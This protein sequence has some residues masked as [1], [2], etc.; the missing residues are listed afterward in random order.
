MTEVGTE[1]MV[2][3]VVAHARDVLDKP[4]G[5]ETLGDLVDLLRPRRGGP[6]PRD[7][8]RALTDALAADNA[9]RARLV[10]AVGAGLR[11][12][13]VVP[14]LVESGVLDDEGVLA[15]LRAALGEW[16]LPP[17]FP[18]DDA[19]AVIPR[20]FRRGADFHWVREMPAAEW[21]RF[22]ELILPDGDRDRDGNGVGLDHE[23]VRL[24]LRRLAQRI[25]G[26]GTDAE[27]EAGRSLSDHEGGPFLELPIAT[28]D[29]LGALDGGGELASARKRLL[30]QT[31]AARKVVHRLRDEKSLYGT[32][33]R[34]TRLTRRLI[35]QL[36]RFELLC[37]LLS[38]TDRG[39]R[40][41]AL[42]VLLKDLVV[43]EQSD[44]RLR[45]RIGQGVDLLAFEITEH[46]AAK[47]EKYI[48]G[49]RATYLKVLRAA[50]LGGAWV[51]VFAIFKLLA[52]KLSLPLAAEAFVYGLNYA[53]C[54]VLIYA[55]G[56]T[57]A[58]KQPAITASA[59]A[60]QLDA[61]GWRQ[62]G[63]EGVARS[64]ERVWRTQFVSF[65]GNLLF[66]FPF[67]ALVGWSIEESAGIEVVT[68]DKARALLEANHAFEGPTLGFAAIAGVLLFVAGLFQGAVDNR[69]VY[70][71]LEAR[72]AEHPRLRLLGAKRA[73]LARL[74]C[75]HAGGIAS[76][77]LLGFLLGSAG[78]VGRIFGLPIDI[79]HI[80][81]SSAHVGVA[82]LDAPQLVDLREALTLVVGVLAIGFVN[83]FVSF[84]LTLT[85]SLT[86]RQVTL[87]QGG[88]LVALLLR[89]FFTSPAA[90][91]FP[92]EDDE[93]TEAAL[94]DPPAQPNA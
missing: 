68:V 82:I 16:I 4:L 88:S 75:K 11:G 63:I 19:R 43:A 35:Q 38:P 70:T 84:V 9:L 87:G 42:A 65:L 37:R 49:T 28:K 18:V 14:V 78:I 85:M 81:F 67:A 6:E 69:V 54:F 44:R 39:Q 25:S 10:E 34:L 74:V 80:A 56:G 90:W 55:T 93:A 91:F 66:A 57:L 46:T 24:A 13:S 47:G 92:L 8:L 48:S 17:V 45:A 5:R 72:L 32:S 86:S 40:V 29:F 73:G 77:V 62:E 71:R 89:R 41:M 3:R 23:S 53:I 60:K 12:V 22:I 59:I 51:G 20:V 36:R 76:N 2:D 94:S 27:I 15:T 58:T 52:K 33:L 30:D 31:R 79:R 1:P 83:F 26:A 7:A 50:L 64:V 21:A 61:D